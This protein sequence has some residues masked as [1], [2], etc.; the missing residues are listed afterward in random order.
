[1][2]DLTSSPLPSSLSGSRNYNLRIL[3]SW[4]ILTAAAYH[5]VVVP[6]KGCSSIRHA[7]RSTEN[8]KPHS[9]RAHNEGGRMKNFIRGVLLRVSL[10]IHEPTSKELMRQ[11]VHVQIATGFSR[12]VV[13]IGMKDVKNP[14][15]LLRS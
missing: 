5:E 1:M 11:Q 9:H 8:T 3:V 12:P 14:A 4:A 10:T 7:T 6:K 2:I 13:R 15:K